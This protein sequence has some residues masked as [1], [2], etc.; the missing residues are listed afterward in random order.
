MSSGNHVIAQALT[1]FVSLHK[2]NV[3]FLAQKGWSRNSNILPL[4]FLAGKLYLPS[5][6]PPCSSSKLLCAL[7]AVCAVLHLSQQIQ[8]H[9]AY[10][11]QGLRAIMERRRCYKHALGDEAVFKVFW[12]GLVLVLCITGFNVVGWL[13]LLSFTRVISPNSLCINSAYP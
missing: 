2:L 4:N 6:P 9:A 13:R 7:R 3:C 11:V 5:P 1:Q 10:P 8:G 12:V